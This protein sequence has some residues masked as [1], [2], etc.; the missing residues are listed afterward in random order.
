MVGSCER[1]KSSKWVEDPRLQEAVAGSEK[2]VWSDS[3]N[4]QLEQQ[5]NSSQLVM[6]CR[7]QKMN[8]ARYLRG[9]ACKDRRIADARQ[10]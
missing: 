10:Q 6:H 2:R 4:G 9:D 3:N 8:W 1:A 5:A 7:M